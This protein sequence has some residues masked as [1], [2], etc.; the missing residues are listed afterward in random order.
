MSVVYQVYESDKNG[1][2]LFQYPDRVFSKA[3][4]LL[5]VAATIAN[6]PSPGMNHGY[7]LIVGEENEIGLYDM[8]I[9]LKPGWTILVN[10]LPFVVSP[11]GEAT[12]F[13]PPI[14][15]EKSNSDEL[16][17]LLALVK[18][19]T[20]DTWEL[21]DLLEQYNVKLKPSDYKTSRAFTSALARLVRKE[22]QT[23]KQVTF[24]EKTEVFLISDPKE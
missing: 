16:E 14:K 3:E 23:N 6:E 8:V 10:P 4:P 5:F 12:T 2:K 11:L 21:L 18:S 1:K 17:T 20:L 19:Q 22:K 13:L 7:Y 24:A 9:A 15:E